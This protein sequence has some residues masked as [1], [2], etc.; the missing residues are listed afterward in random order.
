M[1]I[2]EKE[3]AIL[4]GQ[5]AQG[6]MLSQI[7]ATVAAISTKVDTSLDLS[8]LTEA[9]ATMD[10]HVTQVQTLIGSDTPVTPDAPVADTP[11]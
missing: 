10:Q 1:S 4:A 2:F 7:A 8:P 11:A 3:N 6:Q 5:I 9:I